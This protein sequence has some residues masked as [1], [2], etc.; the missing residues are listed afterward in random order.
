MFMIDLGAQS[1]YSVLGVEPGAPIAEIRASLYKL[2]GDLE[3]QRLKSGSPE[4]KRTIEERQQ[5][6]NKVGDLMTN[7]AK[8]TNYDNVNAHLTFFQ[9]RKATT[10]VWEERDLLLRWLHQTVREFLLSQGEVLR[11][12]NDLERTDFTSDF[13]PNELLE[14]LLENEARERE[15]KS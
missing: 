7:P 5:R 4:E 9:V 15:D 12:I 1:H 6:I 10:P 14:R 3:R 13:T 8:R 11:P 2:S